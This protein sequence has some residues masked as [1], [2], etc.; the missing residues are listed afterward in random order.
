MIL[1]VGRN[2]IDYIPECVEDIT[3]YYSLIRNYGF[4]DTR[5]NETKLLNNMCFNN[6]KNLVTEMRGDLDVY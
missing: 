4:K 5:S 1:A 2:I 3:E 6:H